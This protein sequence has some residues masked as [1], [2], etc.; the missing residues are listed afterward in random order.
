MVD[1]L[2]LKLN[3]YQTAITDELKSTLHREV[4]NDLEEFISTVPFIQHL[5]A[6]ES[7]RGYA[8]DRP[9]EDDGRI[10]VDL[11]KP[12]ILEDMDFFRERA[13]FH[14]EHGKYTN[15]IPNSN[16]NSDYVLFWKQEMERWKYGLVRESDGEW[17]PGELYFYWNYS[18][19][20]LVEKDL[21]KGVSKTKKS[22]GNRV[23]KFPKPWAGDYLFHHYIH[24][25]K[26]NG[27]H[28]KLLKCRGIGFSF[29]TAS[30]SPRNMYIYPGSG[31]P[32]F[33]LAS[34]KGFL[35]GDKGIFGKVVDCLDWIA[36][37]TPLAKLR[38]TDSKKSMEIQ[39]GY[40]DAY[41]VRKGL[42]SSVYG[43]SLKDNPEKARGIRGPLIHYEEDGLFPNLETA[44]GVN[45]KAVEDGNDTFG[46]MLAGGTGGTEGASFE[47]SEKLFYNHG[48][49]N[50][51]GIPNVFDKNVNGVTTCG[52]FW[53]AYMNRN[54]CYDENVGE[55]DVI[56][57]LIEIL[58]DRFIVKYSSSDPK[59]ITQKKAEECIT[60]QEAVLRTSGTI[61]PVAD[62]KDYLETIFPRKESFLA[63]HYVGNLI[64][65]SKG[66]VKWQPN[67]S[68]FPIRSYSKTPADKSG[69][70]E[71]FEMPK[72][73]GKGEISSSRYIAGIDPID[74]DAG[75]SLFSVIVMDVFT[76]RIVA[77]YTGRPRTAKQAYEQTLKLLLFYNAQ[78]NYENNLKGLFS[79][80][81]SKNKLYLLSDTPQILRDMELTKATNL[82]GNKAKGT[83][84]NARTNSWARLL[85]A[86]WLLES[87]QSSDEEDKR[88]NLHRLR[89][90]AYIE[91][92]IYWNPD[93]NFDR[94][95][96][97]G[98]L[99]ILREERVKR[100]ITAKD[101]QYKDA[102][103]L[104]DDDF[105][106][107]NYKPMEEK[108][109]RGRFSYE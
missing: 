59:A 106:N 14:E 6:D 45:R 75:T 3:K 49:Y 1:L 35:Q 20:W 19:I 10:I 24:Q 53:G 38:L 18:P 42:L 102:K 50:I 31:N 80:F 83:N 37:N 23:R 5:I 17:I 105:F 95:S 82:Y 77:E 88:L 52:Y 16:P 69:A 100:S 101:N 72:K 44:W 47:G 84:A 2:N 60:P 98:M 63:E 8:K 78:G 25:A 99:F 34:E 107:R 90:L 89:S 58:E 57:A 66:E 86:D 13:L 15:I 104:S 92:L 96:A 91:E 74:A 71:I 56:K 43:I 68:L 103:R 93:G 94:V 108:G 33:H 28:G 29:K 97:A 26:A 55:S 4:W 67:S 36:E 85:Q 21:K 48:A 65:D 54:G 73:N 9:K 62:L 51:Y 79:Y 22:A 64:Y 46:F 32:N 7:V 87:A 39:L 81:D 30:W 70:I 41:G 11:V 12:H 27:Q 61:F 76:D 40:Q 109:T